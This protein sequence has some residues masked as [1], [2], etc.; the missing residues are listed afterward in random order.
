MNIE[1]IRKYCLS[2]PGAT[3][4]VQWVD[5]LLFKVGGK[6]FMIYSLGQ[7]TTNRMSLKSNPEKFEEITETEFI[8]PAP[9]LGRNK[10]ICIQNGC[11]L[12]LKEINELIAVSYGLV[13][14]KLPAKVKKEIEGNK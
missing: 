11:R 9:Y 12:K 4:Q 7:E 10:W 13:F 6:I 8:I 1:I 2:F 14:E 3:E 5:S